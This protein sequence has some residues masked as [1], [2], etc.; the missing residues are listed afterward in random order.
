MVA[1][2]VLQTKLFDNEDKIPSVLIKLEIEWWALGDNSDDKTLNVELNGQ[3]LSQL[4]CYMSWLI[5]R[6]N[7]RLNTADTIQ[8]RHRKL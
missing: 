7:G 1:Q 4:T 6:N 5:R 8:L 3:S 2:L